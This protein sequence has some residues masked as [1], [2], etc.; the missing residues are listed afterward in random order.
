MEWENSS[1]CKEEYKHF[2]DCMR[3]EQRRYNYIPRDERKNMVLYDYI[4]Q[5]LLVKREQNKFNVTDPD[6]LSAV[7]PLQQKIEQEKQ[8][9]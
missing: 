9:K 6:L 5:R 4:Q 2:Q 7:R 8:A 1:D 3:M